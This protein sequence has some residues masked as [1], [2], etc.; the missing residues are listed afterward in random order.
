MANTGFGLRLVGRLGGGEPRIREYYVPVGDAT[1]LYVGDVVKLTASAGTMDPNNEVPGITRA[2]TGD[3]LLGV[4]IDFKPSASLPYT[5]QYRAAST[6]RYVLVCDDQDAVYE[7]QEDAVS[8]SV[9]AAHIG[10]FYNIPL[11]VQAGST[12]TG[13][14]GTMLTSASAT[15]SA[16]DC[17]IVGVRRD[18]T[19]PALV[20]STSGA[21]LLVKIETNAIN[22]TQSES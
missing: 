4:I 11:N 3:K 12:V 14:S 17:K 15:T 20:G 9:T 10:D 2:A 5:G 16:S 8:N 21:I 19:N 18:P 7:A 13:L 6:A 22:T 1:A